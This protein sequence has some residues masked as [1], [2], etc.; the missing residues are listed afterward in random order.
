MIGIIFAAGIGSR[1]KPFTDY[2]PKALAEINGVPI[3]IRV[4]QKLLDAGAR[5]LIVNLHH[6]PQQIK[7]C[8]SNQ[9]FSSLVEYSDETD[10]L[11]DTGGALAKIAAESNTIKTA[12]GSEPVI[13]HNSD[14]YTDFALADMISAHKQNGSD[15]TILVD[16]HRSSS[17]HFL[18]DALNR[19]QAWENTS[20]GIIRP[21]GIDAQQ[22]KAGAFGGVHLLTPSIISKI[23]RFPNKMICPFSIT[24]W[25][26]DNC[27]KYSIKAYTPLSDFYW[28][29]IGTP[30]KLKE[31]NEA[32]Q[33]LKP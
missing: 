24:D 9:S 12:D 1:L 2:H 6:F 8:I 29:D 21:E 17:R 25:Y 5:R 30:E 10:L 20:T 33:T 23:G 26:I 31:A 32:L 13:V 27:D 7:D 19:L 14:I 22:F 4:A 3:L 16:Y 15:A 28:F 18:F 11:L